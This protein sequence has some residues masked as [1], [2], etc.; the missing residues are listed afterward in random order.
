MLETPGVRPPRQERSRRTFER[1]IDAASAVFAEDG[2]EGL[3]IARVCERAGTSPGAVYTRFE[4][5]DALA[6]AVHDHAMAQMRSEL[7]E[8]YAP[9]ER[10]DALATPELV[11]E[12]AR[13]LIGHFRGNAALI[14]AIVLRSAAD[15]TM[16]ARGAQ[17]VRAVGDAFV[18]RLSDRLGDYPRTD[19]LAA[20]RDAFAVLFEAISWDIAFGSEFRQAGAFGSAPDARL[21]VLCRMMLLTPEG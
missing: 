14:R 10:W 20:V 13:V 9:S 7:E 18:G 19:P 21:P 6:L 8:A 1:V 5:K 17:S 4:N 2:Y 3:T 15:P 12:C 16:R 11:E